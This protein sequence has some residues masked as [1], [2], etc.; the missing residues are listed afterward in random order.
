MTRFLMTLIFAKI[1][2]PGK[3]HQWCYLRAY[4]WAMSR[5][6]FVSTLASEVMPATLQAMSLEE[7]KCIGT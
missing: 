4:L 2:S 1:S 7:K 3:H 6:S 5:S